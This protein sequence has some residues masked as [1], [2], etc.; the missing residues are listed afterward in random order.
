M[1]TIIKVSIVG[2]LMRS[3]QRVKTSASKEALKKGQDSIFVD[4]VTPSSSGSAIPSCWFLNLCI[5]HDKPKWGWRGLYFHWRSNWRYLDPIDATGR[6]HK[7]TGT[8]SGQMCVAKSI[9]TPSWACSPSMNRHI[10]T[11]IRTCPWRPLPAFDLR[12]AGWNEAYP[13]LL[14]LRKAVARRILLARVRKS[15]KSQKKWDTSI[16]VFLSLGFFPF[17]IWC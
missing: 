15:G 17:S 8:Y 3:H 12:C 5:S 11:P 6:M 1:D 10:S 2:V 13:T 4:P 7:S 16:I 9:P 14:Y